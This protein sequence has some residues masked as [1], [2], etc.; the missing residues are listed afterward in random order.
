MLEERDFSPTTGP[1]YTLAGDVPWYADQVA[2]VLAFVDSQSR[3]PYMSAEVSWHSCHM[4]KTDTPWASD[5][6]PLK[7]SPALAEFSLL[8]A[9]WGAPF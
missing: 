7:L 4:A 5:G 6:C 2:C 9:T 3:P 1:W 8:P